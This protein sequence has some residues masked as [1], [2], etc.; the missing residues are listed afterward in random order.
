MNAS[1]ESR[2]LPSRMLSAVMVCNPL[3]LLSPVCLLY[4]IYR[5]VVAP[6]LFATDTDNTIFNFLALAIYVLMVCVTSTLLARKRIVPDT[7]MLL[8]LNGLLFVAPFILIAHGV[9]LEGHLAVALGMLGIAMGK[10]QLEIFRRRLPESFVTPQLSIGAALV[11]AANFAAPLIFRR[12]LEN[13]ENN[14]EVWGVTSAYGWYVVFPLLVAW[15]NFIPVRRTSATIWARPWFAPLLYLL[16]VAG[17][18]I[19]LWTVAYV[20]DR[21]LHAHQ[22]TV[23]VWVLAWT[24]FRR[25]QMFE[26]AWAARIQIVAPILGI[27]TPA[28]GAIAGLDLRIAALLYLLNLPILAA[29]RSALPAVAMAGV[30]ILAAICCMPVPWLTEISPTL[31]R[32]NFV[33]LV[34]VAVTVGGV[35]MIRDARAGLLAA[36]GVGIL[37]AACGFSK[38][39][40]LN[41]FVLFLFLHQLRWKTTGMNEHVLLALAGVIW[42][43]QTLSLELR[44]STDARAA[45]FV[46]TIVVTLCLRN[47]SL[48]VATSLVPAFASIVILLL[49]PMH[50]ST[51]AVTTAP[52]GVLAIAIGFALLATGAWDSVR[53]NLTAHAH[54]K[55]A[56]ANTDA[57]DSGNLPM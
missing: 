4:G 56:H 17:T 22:F 23:A 53:R 16:W 6:T 13:N 33:A 40:A 20:D 44:N 45:S 30:S 39:L 55:E 52:S 28:M 3:L 1:E 19:Q 38:T 46:A 32:P 26:P 5:A 31:T 9:F 43:A 8:L 11:L 2:P 14:N 21:Q 35:G 24:A 48:G 50:W 36:I 18:S 37:A 54:M 7:V 25:A 29:A 10:G 57:D 47:A 15:L 27:L 12:G 41:A 49:Q 51:K 42:I 34:I